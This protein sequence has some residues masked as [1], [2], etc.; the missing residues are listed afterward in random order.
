M[1]DKAKKTQDMIMMQ[2]G[3]DQALKMEKLDHRNLLTSAIN[4]TTHPDCR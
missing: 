1:R 2:M 4:Y 3:N